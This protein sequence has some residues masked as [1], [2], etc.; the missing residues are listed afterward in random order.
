MVCNFR[1]DNFS[2]EKSHDKAKKANEFCDAN[3]ILKKAIFLEFGFKTATHYNPQITTCDSIM[4]TFG[5]E[6]V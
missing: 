4:L 1:A 3:Q 2:I 6:L 5:T